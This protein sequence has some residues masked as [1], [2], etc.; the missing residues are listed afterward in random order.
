MATLIQKLYEYFLSLGVVGLGI[1]TFIESLGIPYGT[2]AVGLGAGSLIN[3]GHVSF[4]LAFIVTLTGL[5]LGSICSYYI[6]YFG[7]KLK[8][9]LS[10]K[11]PSKTME[12]FGASM[13]KSG[14]FVIALAQLYGPTRTWISIPAGVA[15]MNIK[16][17]IFGTVIGGALYSVGILSLSLVLTRVIK[18]FLKYLFAFPH[19]YALRGPFAILLI[20]IVSVGWWFFKKLTTSTNQPS[21]QPHL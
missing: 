21:V 4:I 15:K 6:G 7:G 14:F 11:P 5:V 10:A 1:G 16:V 17:F 20:A 8:H 19:V 2:M 9:K 12:K 18:D 3:S 13:E